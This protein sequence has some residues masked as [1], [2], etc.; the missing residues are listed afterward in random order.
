MDLQE[1]EEENNE[2]DRENISK[3]KGAYLHKPLNH[4]LKESIL[5]VKNFRN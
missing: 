1:K 5:W 4:R 2:K 3:K